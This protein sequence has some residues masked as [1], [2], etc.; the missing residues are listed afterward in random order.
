[1]LK[2]K[3]CYRWMI[4]ITLY[5]LSYMLLYFPSIIDLQCSSVIVKYMSDS[6]HGPKPS[7]ELPV[8]Y[9]T[10]SFL[11]IFGWPWSYYCGDWCLENYVG[12]DW[13]VFCELS[14]VTSR[15]E[16]ERDWSIFYNLPLQLELDRD[17]FRKML[18][19]L[20]NK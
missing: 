4:W 1:M 2:E 15:Q 8:S 6:N 20:F 7:D 3:I 9:T 12:T 5:L 17:Y 14:P 18:Q 19:Q 11:G 16:R 10:S 13:A